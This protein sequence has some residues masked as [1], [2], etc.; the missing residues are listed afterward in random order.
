MFFLADDET[1][2]GNAIIGP[3]SRLAPGAL[4]VY[5]ETV[6]ISRILI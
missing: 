1:G 3:R 4:G 2:A 5:K 6:K